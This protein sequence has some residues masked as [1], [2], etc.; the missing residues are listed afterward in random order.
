MLRFVIGYFLAHAA[1][2]TQ[3]RQPADVL[4]TDA[5]GNGIGRQVDEPV[6]Q[7]HH[8][9]LLGCRGIAVILR[10]RGL[11]EEGLVDQFGAQQHML[12]ARR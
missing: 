11:P 8:G 12:L 6:D 1:Q 5:G 3:Y 7:P 2:F 10:E 4:D 9:S